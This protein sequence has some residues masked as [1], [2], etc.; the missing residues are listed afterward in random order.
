MAGGPL[1]TV[2]LEDLALG[3]GG[4]LLVDR[5]LRDLPAGERLVV[6]GTDPLLGAHLPAW[7]RRRGD[8]VESY[9]PERGWMVVRGRADGRWSGARRAGA[10]GGHGVVERADPTW[11]LAAR[12]ALVEEG[13]AGTRADLLD[14]ADVWCDLAPRLYMQAAA[15]QWDPARAIPWDEPIDHPPEVEQALVQVLTYLIENELAALTVPS[16]FIARIHP[17]YREV[18]QLLAVQCADEARHV[19]VFARRA[20]LRSAGL[21]TST[22]GGRASLATLVNE[23]DYHRA[24]FLLAVLGEGTFLD[25]L[26]WLGRHAPDLVTARIFQLVLSDE[27]RHVAFGQSHLEHTLAGDPSVRERLRRAAE[28][29]HREL[30]ATAGLNEDVRDALVLIAAGGWAPDRIATAWRAFS[31]L[32]QSMHEGRKRRLARLGFTD[33]EASE[34][35]DLHT[36][37]FM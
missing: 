36:D 22:V 37:N 7:C 35:S 1:S 2:N 31:A 28:E 6:S 11:G 19:E 18:V 30:Q 3:A 29:R 21:G 27:A 9:I 25:L 17:H 4:H 14:R 32:L 15:N 33:R 23:P 10:P 5:A 34:L 20:G 24:A 13:G 8:R 26:G 12:G 16:A